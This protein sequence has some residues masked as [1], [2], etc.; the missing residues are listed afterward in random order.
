MQRTLV[1]FKPDTIQRSL[2]GTLI[3]RFEQKGLKLVG[4][5][6]MSMPKALCDEHYS[7]MTSKPFYPAIVE[8]MTAG[9][10]V[11]L[12][13]EGHDAVMVVRK[14]CGLTAESE[15][16]AGT[17]RGDYAKSIDSNMIHSSDSLETAAAE[18]PRFFN[19]N[20]LFEY[21]R[22]FTY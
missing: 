11:A 3:T 6:M 2:V 18:V 15:W 9:P 21:G 7:H 20:E 16:V 4:L 19:E 8:F 12:A 14:M 1:L 5:K 10:I 17:I 22:T 13:I